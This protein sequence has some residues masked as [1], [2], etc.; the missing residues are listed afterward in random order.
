MVKKAT[1][2]FNRQEKT[3]CIVGIG[4]KKIIHSRE[5]GLVPQMI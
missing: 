2:S 3:T 1:S 4:E 5:V